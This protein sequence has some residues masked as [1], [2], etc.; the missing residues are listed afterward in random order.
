MIIIKNIDEIE[1]QILK[2][3]KKIGSQ[4]RSQNFL[5]KMVM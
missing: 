2:K 3:E 5:S 4:N 1:A